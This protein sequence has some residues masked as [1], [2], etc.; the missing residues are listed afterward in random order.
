[1]ISDYEIACKYKNKHQNALK[2]GIEFNLSLMT[3]YNLCRSKRCH[4]TGVKLTAENF[5]FDR[6]DNQKGYVPGN[7]VACCHNFNQLK[8]DYLEHTTRTTFS[9]EQLIEALTKLKGHLDEQ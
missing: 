3:V 7:V 8:S 6:V 4:F 5:T 2:A 1:M 9:V